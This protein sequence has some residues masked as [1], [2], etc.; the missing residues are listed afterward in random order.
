MLGLSALLHEGLCCCIYM[1]LAR[2]TAYWVVLLAILLNPD[3]PD[4]R[5][6]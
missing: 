4:Q 6:Y 5:S 3:A 2:N 1:G